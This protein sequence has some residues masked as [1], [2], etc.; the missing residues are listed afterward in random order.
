MLPPRSGERRGR[1]PQF[2]LPL[3]LSGKR[4]PSIRKPPG[5]REGW[6]RSH[7]RIPTSCA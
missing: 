2:L 1:T 6:G 7:R 5:E 3:A 4:T